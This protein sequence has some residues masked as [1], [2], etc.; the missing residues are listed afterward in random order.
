MKLI[1]LQYP[2]EAPLTKI[3]DDITVLAKN[4]GQ[5]GYRPVVAFD[6]DAASLTSLQTKL[7]QRQIATTDAGD[8][9]L[10]DD[11]AVVEAGIPYAVTGGDVTFTVAGNV[12]TG[13]TF[14]PD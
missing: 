2:D 7:T 5:K 10:P 13:G 12:I 3:L 4:N 11:Q 9:E 14:T 1:Q 8:G 6:Y